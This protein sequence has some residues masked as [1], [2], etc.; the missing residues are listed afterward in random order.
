MKHDAILNLIKKLG[1]LEP[2]KTFLEEDIQK[3]NQEIK[4]ADGVE[5]A[6]NQKFYN[7]IEGFLKVCEKKTEDLKESDIAEFDTS[8]E[9]E[10]HDTYYEKLH[11]L[12]Q[13]KNAQEAIETLERLG[14]LERITEAMEALINLMALDCVKKANKIV[15]AAKEAKFCSV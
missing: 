1:G 4:A 6:A 9:E 3:L 10:I 11:R 7:K 2:V 8:E 13:L 12:K 15:I 5:Q 14:G